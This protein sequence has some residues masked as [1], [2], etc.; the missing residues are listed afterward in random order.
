M[1]PLEILDRPLDD[2]DY[3]EL[4]K[5]ITTSAKATITET[6]EP[7]DTL[8]DKYSNITFRNTLGT[9]TQDAPP[10]LPPSVTLQLTKSHMER[11]HSSSDL[12][13]A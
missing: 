2:T 9:K 5:V 8:A 1:W 12:H 10:K 4:T 11:P 7:T 3:R 13:I 6:F